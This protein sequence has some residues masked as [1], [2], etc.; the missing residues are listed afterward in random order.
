MLQRVVN[1]MKNAATQEN[2]SDMGDVLLLSMDKLEMA[3]K[4]SEENANQL[5]WTKIKM[6]NH[7]EKFSKKELQK[8]EKLMS[9]M[10]EE[11]S[12]LDEILTSM[13]NLRN[14]IEKS[15]TSA[16][17]EDADVKS[18]ELRETERFR[19]VASD[20]PAEITGNFQD[21][22]EEAQVDSANEMEIYL[23]ML[24]CLEKQQ[25][26]LG[27]Q[28]S[29]QNQICELDAYLKERFLGKNKEHLWMKILRKT[30]LQS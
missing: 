2:W 3:K 17:C 5:Y 21:Q 25:N 9:Q 15:M 8:I 30:K 4:K 27:R 11:I 16:V 29:I 13:K 22:Q 7:Q 6:E 10:D 28:R 23:G 18:E 20:S 19:I 1:V 26:C 12:E 14:I 24:Q